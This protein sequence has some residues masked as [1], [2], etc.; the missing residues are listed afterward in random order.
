MVTDYNLY[1]PKTGIFLKIWLILMWVL[2][3]I[4]L[5]G[6]MVV[7]CIKPDSTDDEPLESKAEK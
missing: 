6:G 2:L 5:I 3:G 1:M 4:C 7:C